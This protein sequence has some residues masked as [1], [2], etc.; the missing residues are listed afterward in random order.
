MSLNGVFSF[1]GEYSKA[2]KLL[3]KNERCINVD[4]H[5]IFERGMK[6]KNKHLQSRML[7]TLNSSF[8]QIQVSLSTIRIPNPPLHSLIRIETV[9][10]D[11]QCKIQNECFMT[12][13]HCEKEHYLPTFESE[14]KEITSSR[15]E[16]RDTKYLQLPN[17]RKVSDYK[18]YY[19]V[20][21]IKIGSNE[22]GEQTTGTVFKSKVSAFETWKTNPNSFSFKPT[23]MSV[24]PLYHD[25]DKQ[26]LNDQKHSP[27]MFVYDHTQFLHMVE[28]SHQF[29]KSS[30]KL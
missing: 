2:K 18:N 15:V 3:L 25:G 14:T 8:N 12:T 19:L 22:S 1:D 23:Y 7:E 21:I 9:L 29:S 4:L 30:F 16:F 28:R 11:S 10:I 5:R 13:L 24:L 26:L 17:V 6:T 20:F 27:K